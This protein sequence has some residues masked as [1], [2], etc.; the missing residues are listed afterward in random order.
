MKWMI[1][2]CFLFSEEKSEPIKRLKIIYFPN[3]H[4]Y[5]NSLR[6]GPFITSLTNEH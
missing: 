5:V 2:I 4:L 1:L 3:N 6:H